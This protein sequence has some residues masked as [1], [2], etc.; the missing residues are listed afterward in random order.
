MGREKPFS[1]ISWKG[2]LAVAL[3]VFNETE[4]ALALEMA[5]ASGEGGNI[6]GIELPVCEYTG[7]IAN[8]N[9]RARNFLIMVCASNN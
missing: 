9:T 2:I 6:V 7:R 4:K 1:L 8:D 5:A 3:P